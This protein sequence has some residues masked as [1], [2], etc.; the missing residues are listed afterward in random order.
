MLEIQLALHVIYNY[1][2]AFGPYQMELNQYPDMQEEDQT[3]GI[4]SEEK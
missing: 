2:T 1:T 4:V 3:L